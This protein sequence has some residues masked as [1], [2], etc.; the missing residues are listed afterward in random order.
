MKC[1]CLDDEDQSA[2]LD[3]QIQYCNG[4]VIGSGSALVV[5]IAEKETRPSRKIV[6][7]SEKTRPGMSV[8]RN[9]LAGVRT[10]RCEVPEN[11]MKRKRVVALGGERDTIHGCYVSRWAVRRSSFAGWT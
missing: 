7:T 1:S 8:V 4:C 11:E 9:D 6:G 2:K 5:K 3:R 10:N